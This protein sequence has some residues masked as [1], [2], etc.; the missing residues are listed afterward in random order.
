MWLLALQISSRKRSTV[1]K[2]V[3]CD[4]VAYTAM[5]II[6]YQNYPTGSIRVSCKRVSC[7]CSFVSAR[8]F[9]RDFFMIC[10]SN[11]SL[12]VASEIKPNT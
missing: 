6:S 10:V 12:R 4:S 5:R 1:T 11:V 9:R 3:A 7:Y 8:S 2:F